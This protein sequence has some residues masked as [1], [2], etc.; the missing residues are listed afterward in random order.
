MWL[1]SW[2]DVGTAL[3]VGV[4]AY[5]V[6][7]T[8]LRLSGARTLAKLNAFDLI[9]TVALGSTLATVL[10]SSVGV[11]DAGGRGP[12]AA[13]RPA[14]RRRLDVGA[15]PVVPSR[16]AI[17][18]RCCCCGTARSSPTGFRD[19]RMTSEEVRQAVRRREPG[20]SPDVA[21]VVLETDGT[22]SVIPRSRLGD[23]SALMDLP[24]ADD[25]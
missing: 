9:V 11:A 7:V 21:A 19:A 5:G 3:L 12:G 1:G 23:G 15:V 24:P 25:G 16:G 2:A 10:L 14:V 22:L 6:L 8:M 17:A 18:S 13:R 20:T 4:V